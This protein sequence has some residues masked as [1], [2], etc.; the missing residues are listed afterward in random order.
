MDD[1]NSR[2]LSNGG[3]HGSV[4]PDIIKGLCGDIVSSAIAS[5]VSR[6]SEQ[7]L[8]LRTPSVVT[9]RDDCNVG[10]GSHSGD[11]D[12]DTNSL[13]SKASNT[14]FVT[15]VVGLGKTSSNTDHDADLLRQASVH[16]ELS[17]DTAEYQ[18]VSLTAEQFLRNKKNSLLITT[19]K[20]D[21]GTPQSS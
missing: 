12:L 10:D 2:R 7:S 21:C 15:T 1:K 9:E 18:H 4:T 16:S 5:A 13:E 8:S 20:A 11:G 14:S 19:L 6:A 3:A 17:A